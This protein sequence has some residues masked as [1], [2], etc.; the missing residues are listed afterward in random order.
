M[1]IIG[2]E[3]PVFGNYQTNMANHRLTSRAILMG[4]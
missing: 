1:H 4:A 3:L 2:K